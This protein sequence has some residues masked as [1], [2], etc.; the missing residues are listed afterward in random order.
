V[1]AVASDTHKA[2]HQVS[3]L[4]GRETISQQ[5]DLGSAAA[6]ATQGAATG[7]HPAPDDAMRNFV[8]KQVLLVLA[9]ANCASAATLFSEDFSN[10]SAGWTLGPNWQIG[11]AVAGCGDP[12]TD[13]DGTPGGGIAGVV[14]GGCA[15]T[16]ALHGYYYLTSPVVDTS[17]SEQVFLS[18]DRYLL[19]D[20]TPYMKNVVEVYN[21]TAWVTIFETF[22]TPG[23]V[24]TQWVAQQF[25]VSAQRDTS[26]QVRWGY[27]IGSSGAFNVGSWNIDN[28]RIFDGRDD[29]SVPEPATFLLLGGGLL[30]LATLRRRRA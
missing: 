8:L 25:D 7:I 21:G 30:G 15:P 13:A 20:Y 3:F 9:A 18:F 11:A 10:N 14:I 27:N 6:L 28:V 5:Q 22:G 23:I 2:A 29:V 17:G 24:D 19:S 16:E 1:R 26:F 4:F 12:G